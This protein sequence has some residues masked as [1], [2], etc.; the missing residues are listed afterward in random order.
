MTKEILSLTITVF[1]FFALV[2]VFSHINK[3][4]LVMSKRIGK[5]L[6]GRENNTA[7]SKKGRDKRR[8]SADKPLMVFTKIE[9]SLTSAG[10]LIRPS[11]FLTGWCLAG[12]LPPLLLLLLTKNIVITLGALLVGVFLPPYFLHIKKAKRVELFEKQLVEAIAVIC[13]S[14]K[15]GLTLQQAMISIAGEMPEPISREF[16]RVI[17]EINLGS[18]MEKALTNMAER[19]NSKNFMM[20]VSAILIQRQIG[21]NLSDILANIAGTIKER[22]KIKSEIKVLTTTGRSSGKVVGLLPIFI[23]LFFM[24]VNPA[25]VESFFHTTAGIMMLVAAAVLETVGFMVI[26]SIV[27]IKY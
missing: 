14:L 27:N 9:N 15:S 11:E 21:G 23:L 7:V 10:L 13:N 4:K 8:R 12:L 6:S 22:F 1:V 19:L 3:D 16:G 24:L 2:A 17:R 25:Y 5:I 26:R 20:I 18:N